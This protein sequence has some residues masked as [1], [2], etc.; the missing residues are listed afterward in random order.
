MKTNQIIIILA[1]LVITAGGLFFILSGKTNTMSPAN[2]TSVPLQ[3]DGHAH[4]H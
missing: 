2:N 3:E 4:E 1:I